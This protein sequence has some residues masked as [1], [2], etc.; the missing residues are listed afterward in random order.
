MA[1]Q[2]HCIDCSVHK[3]LLLGVHDQNFVV[4]IALKLTTSLTS[5]QVKYSN[6]HEDFHVQGQSLIQSTGILATIGD[7]QRCAS[8][9]RP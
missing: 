3:S 2:L 7:Y 4:I 6:L 9:M 5:M 8:L 1:F